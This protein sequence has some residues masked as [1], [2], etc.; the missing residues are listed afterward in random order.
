MI[1]TRGPALAA[2]EKFLEN[3]ANANT[4]NQRR[5]YLREY[6]AYLAA[7]RQCA[8][9]Q[10][11]VGDLLHRLNIQ[12]WMDA[13]RRGATRR[14]LGA[15]GPH[16]APSSMAARTTTVNTFS[17]FC[18]A[19]LR[20]SRPRIETVQR[21]TSLEAHRTLRLLAEHQPARMRVDVWERSVAVIAL[22]V[23]TRRGL[24][25]LHGMRLPDVDLDRVLPRARVTG[26]WYPLDVVSARVLTRWLLRHRELTARHDGRGRSDRLW[27]T[28]GPGR[29]GAGRRV[30]P[31]GFP[32]RVRTLEAAHRKL[33]TQALGVPL[34]IEQ[35]CGSP[36]VPLPG[37]VPAR[38]GRLPAGTLLTRGGWEGPR[39]R[40]PV[41][42]RREAVTLS[43]PYRRWLR[44]EPAAASE[45]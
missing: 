23:C 4:R 31:A 17:R 36:G 11:T 28:T 33:T 15:R 24:S 8:E 5:T 42:G 25:D 22:A 16:A 30:A 32:A 29:S 39:T 45:S 10:L 40:P 19:P 1:D 18:G 6:I 2:V 12:D 37:A 38:P 41:T 21:L 3:F 34:R 27:V 43:R 9:N 14:R 20:L 44:S 13:A 7:S 35:F 26:E